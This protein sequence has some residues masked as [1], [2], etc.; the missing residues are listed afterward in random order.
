MK[1]KERYSFTDEPDEKG[2]WARLCYN[3]NEVMV[4]WVNRLQFIKTP[5]EV[6]TIIFSVSCYFPTRPN[7]DSPCKFANFAFFDEAKE[8]VEKEWNGFTK[9][10]V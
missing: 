9:S 10:I 1:W 8:W 4:A 6:E 7:T 5:E 2:R 3:D